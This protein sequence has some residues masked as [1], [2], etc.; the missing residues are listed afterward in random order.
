[1]V[2]IK[3]IMNSLEWNSNYFHGERT[4]KIEKGKREN[5]NRK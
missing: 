1:M 3:N 5:E 2:T 4:K